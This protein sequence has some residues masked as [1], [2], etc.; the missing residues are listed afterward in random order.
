MCLQALGILTSP[1]AFS[2]D[3]AACLA[4]RLSTQKRNDFNLKNDDLA[5][6][7]NN[8]EPCMQCVDLL[9]RLQEVC[10]ACLSAANYETFCTEVG[11][12]FHSQLLEHLRK[13]QISASGG[14]VLTK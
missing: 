10:K 4:A 12:V 11:V 1:R 9:E 6:A 7:G 14:L 3:V 13:Y 2:P 8:T 5:L